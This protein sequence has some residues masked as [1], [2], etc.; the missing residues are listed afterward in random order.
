MVGGGGWSGARDGLLMKGEMVGE[1][2]WEM[3]SSACVE[4][5]LVLETF[6]DAR[7]RAGVRK[8]AR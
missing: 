6:C 3:V 1:V 2:C 4:V 5:G 8:H 7:W